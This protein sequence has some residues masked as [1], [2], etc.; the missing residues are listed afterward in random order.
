MTAN[1]VSDLDLS[2]SEARAN[3][4]VNHE[5]NET[6]IYIL[7]LPMLQESFAVSQSAQAL[8]QL[9]GVIYTRRK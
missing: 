6:E 4:S 9:K 5:N 8:L 3:I 1:H 2:Y 7:C